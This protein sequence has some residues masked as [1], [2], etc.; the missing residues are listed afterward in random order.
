M[1]RPRKQ[2]VET[3]EEVVELNVQDTIPQ[4]KPP[5]QSIEVPTLDVQSQI[6]GQSLNALRAAQE[7][8][9][10][11]AEEAKLSEEEPESA[12]EPVSPP[13]VVWDMNKE[14]EKPKVYYGVYDRGDLIFV[15]DSESEQ[16]DAFLADNKSELEA[17]I[18]DL[19]S[20]VTNEQ[21]I[22]FMNCPPNTQ[23]YSSYSQYLAQQGLAPSPPKYKSWLDY[24]RNAYNGMSDEEIAIK[25]FGNLRYSFSPVKLI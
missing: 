8:A 18:V 15:T 9:K 5:A 24:Y 11:A 6:M 3:V 22:I 7:A 21:D 13:L 14:P 16:I 10:K 4:E 2:S 12:E 25:V 23:N 17:W 20:E 1:A 19:A